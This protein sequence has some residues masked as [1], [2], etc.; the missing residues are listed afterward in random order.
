MTP[1]LK[2]S[3]DTPLLHPI[4]TDFKKNIESVEAFGEKKKCLAGGLGMLESVSA[5]FVGKAFGYL[6]AMLYFCI[7]VIIRR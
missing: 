5:L 1:F 7:R 3:F 4:R 2:F 6:T